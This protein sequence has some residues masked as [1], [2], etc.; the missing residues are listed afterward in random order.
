MDIRHTRENLQVGK[1]Y[2]FDTSKVSYGRYVGEEGDNLQFTS[3]N[4]GPEK[5]SKN[6][7][8][9]I[10]DGDIEGFILKQEGLDIQQVLLSIYCRNFEE[11]LSY[12]PEGIEYRG[13]IYNK[14]KHF[15]LQRTYEEEAKYGY[16]ARLKMIDAC[17]ELC[18]KELEK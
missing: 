14:P 6:G 17:L 1:V 15:Q 12:I 3:E 9:E 5:V 13:I 16:P 7:Y 11:M 2:Y 4:P 18:I 10:T 8:I